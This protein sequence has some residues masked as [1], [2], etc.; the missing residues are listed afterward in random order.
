MVV[1]ELHRGKR[2]VG[3]L[4]AKAGCDISTMS[5]HL[6][7]LRNCGIVA[8]EKSASTVLCRLATPCIMDF[9]CCIDGVL[10]GNPGSC[11]ATG[12]ERGRRA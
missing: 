10:A 6:A 11:P 4:A 8:V 3:D 1:E 2:S 5:R 7:V 9:F 12:H